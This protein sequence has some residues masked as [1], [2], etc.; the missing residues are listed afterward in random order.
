MSQTEDSIRE[1]SINKPF[2]DLASSLDDSGNTSAWMSKKQRTKIEKH[3]E[4]L[5]NRIGL[6]SQE[7]IK[8][9]K[10]I[11]ETKKKTD[12]LVK[13]KLLNYENQ[14]LVYIRKS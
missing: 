3:I 5:K 10:K 13:L 7:E 11:L 2:K 14:L 12:S 4:I 6:L 9:K 8:S 1:Y